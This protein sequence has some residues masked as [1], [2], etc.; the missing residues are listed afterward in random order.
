MHKKQVNHKKA[1]LLEQDIA[2]N[3]IAHL[4]KPLFIFMF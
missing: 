3:E 4:L 1:E 2:L